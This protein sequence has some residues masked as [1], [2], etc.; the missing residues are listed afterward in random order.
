M[1]GKHHDHS[2]LDGEP[3]TP[4]PAALRLRDYVQHKDGCDSRQVKCIDIGEFVPKGLACTCGLSDLLALL[5]PGGETEKHGKLDNFDIEVSVAAIMQFYEDG[6]DSGEAFV[7]GIIDNLLAKAAPQPAE[8]RWQP[9][10]TAPKDETPVLV[11]SNSLGQLVAR[12]DPLIS[13]GEEWTRWRSHWDGSVLA[14]EPKW[15]M[16]VSDPLPAPPTEKGAE[17]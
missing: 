11:Y 1:N 3:M 12:F 16:R 6:L 17:G 2:G 9:I 14:S 7:R 15:W 10:A 13:E 5:S 4:D 8:T